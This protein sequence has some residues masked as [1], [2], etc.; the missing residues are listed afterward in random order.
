MAQLMA[1]TVVVCRCRYL[2]SVSVFRIFV[3]I[4]LRRFGIWYRYFKISRY[5]YRYSVFCHCI[6]TISVFICRYFG[7]FSIQNT[8]VGIGV[9][10]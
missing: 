6:Y 3:G 9:G 10:I 2:T 7:I 1:H 5:R 4:F 8:D